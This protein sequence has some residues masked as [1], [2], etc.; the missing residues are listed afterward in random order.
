MKPENSNHEKNKTNKT[1]FLG[2]LIGGEEPQHKNVRRSHIPFRLNLLFFVIFGLFVAL[3]ARLSYIQII[4][5][6]NLVKN[7]ELNLADSVELTEST[8]RGQIYDAKGRLLAETITN[9]AITYTRGNNV[10]SK[11]IFQIA[12]QLNSLID[13]PADTKMTLR[14]KK[15]YYLMN[16]ERYAIIERR[17]SD[18]EKKDKNGNLLNPS[19]YYAK[20]VEKVTEDDVNFSAD[21]MKIVTIFTR[22][23][24][25][26]SLKTVYV[27]SEGV[28]D[29]ELA[30]VAENGRELKGIGTGTDWARKYTDEPLI[31]GFLGSVTTQQEGLPADSLDDYL[32]KGY[33]LN[34]RVGTS[35]LELQYEDVL[36]GKKSVYEVNLDKEGNIENQL[37]KEAG[38]KGDNLV[39]TIDTEFQKQ[40]QEIVDRQFN[41]IALGVGYYSPGAY[42]TVMDIETGAI[43][44]MAGVSHQPGTGEVETDVMGTYLNAFTPGSTVK[45]ATLAIGYENGIIFGNDTLI[46]Q[47]IYIGNSTQSKSSWFNRNSSMPVTAAQALEYSSN[48]Y[49]M[50]IAIGMLGREY[51]RGMKFPY[52]TDQ[53]DAYEKMRATYAEFGLGTSTGLDLPKEATGISVTDYEDM[54]GGLILDLSFGQYDTYTSVQ[55]A[56]YMA[57]VAN[58]GKRVAAHVVDKVYGNDDMGNLDPTN[59]IQDLNGQVLNE[60]NITED[61]LGIIQTGLRNVVVGNGAY[62]TGGALAGAAGRLHAKTGT[63]ETVYVGEDGTVVNTWNSNL[64]A[65]TNT[66]ER[67]I[68]ISVI[69]PQLTIDNLTSKAI[70]I[71]VVNAYYNWL[72]QEN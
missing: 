54:D 49:M 32:A 41:S 34:D 43:Y 65:Y 11:S 59:V 28:T 53:V 71:E 48:S 6:E 16:D 31:R 35:N 55:L 25:A 23:N 36:K 37:V 68:A 4:N 9:S 62:T 45:A 13:V 52:A 39:L 57:T 50:Q 51:S 44:A 29:A 26:A 56:Q 70:A 46:D 42:V 33:S 20:L 67:D 40:V 19:E 66:G 17:L 18:A 15:D 14:D 24:A 38:E 60:I 7:A 63:A 2:N 21:E 64:V 22:M 30:I 5:G 58:G 69:L 27:K 47:P 8:P 72:A 10:S 3:I 12:N 1:A 61:Q